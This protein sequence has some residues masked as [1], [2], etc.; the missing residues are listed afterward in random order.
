MPD[1]R[2]CSWRFSID[3]SHQVLAV[4]HSECIRVLAVD[5]DFRAS[6]LSEVLCQEHAYC[7]A[8]KRLW[9]RA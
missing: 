5:E 7:V 1:M 2:D 8:L 3:H 9:G 6:D 4:P